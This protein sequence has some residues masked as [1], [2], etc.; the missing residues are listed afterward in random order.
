[1]MKH[2]GRALFAG[3]A[4]ALRSGPLPFAD[5]GAEHRAGGAGGHGAHGRRRDHGR[6]PSRAACI[7][8][9]QFHPESVLTPQGPQLMGNFL[10]LTAALRARLT[11]WRESCTTAR[12][13]RCAAGTARALH[14]TK[15]GEL[16][17]ALTDA[18]AAAGAGRRAAGRAARQGRDA[19]KSCAASRWACARWR[20]GRRLQPGIAAVDIVGTGGD[21]SGSFNLSTGAALLTAACGPAGD[22]ARQ[23]L[24]IE[25]A[26]AAPMCSRRWA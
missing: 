14:R 2:D 19:P 12:L 8:G 22:Q 15:R 18:G 7:E 16:L 17:V 5:R 11:A 26:P 1:M 3:I 9:V 10:R 21:K 13:A 20:G 23:S 24:G 4:A 6:A 25:Q